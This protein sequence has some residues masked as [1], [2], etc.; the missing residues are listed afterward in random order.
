MAYPD[1]DQPQIIAQIQAYFQLSR[2]V[3]PGFLQGTALDPVNGELGPATSA[4]IAAYIQ[5]HGLGE[6]VRPDDPAY[7]QNLY[8]AV[9][10]GLA[11]NPAIQARLL[12]M[13]DA[14][15]QNP[16]ALEE[17]ALSLFEEQQRL[18]FRRQ[19]TP[20]GLDDQTRDGLH[21]EIDLRLVALQTEFGQAEEAYRL[22][23][24][25]TDPEQRELLRAGN[26][27][28]GL[29]GQVLIA[30]P[31]EERTATMAAAGS[32]KANGN[33]PFQRPA[34]PQVQLA[35]AEGVIATDA[36]P[37]AEPEP[38]PEPE[39]EQPVT[40]GATRQP[41]AQPP[42]R[43][44]ADDYSI[45]FMMNVVLNNGAYGVHTQRVW[46]DI[47]ENQIA[48][49]QAIENY[50]LDFARRY[51]DANGNRPLPDATTATMR[52]QLVTQVAA[53]QTIEGQI[54]GVRPTP[55]Q[56]ADTYIQNRVLPQM[57]QGSRDVYQAMQRDGATFEDAANKWLDDNGG[58]GNPQEREA[59]LAGMRA[60]IDAIPRL[61]EAVRAYE[62]I[63]PTPEDALRV[64]R[65]SWAGIP[66]LPNTPD[67]YA[68]L[69]EQRIAHYQTAAGGDL[70]PMTA[71]SR[72]A[73]DIRAQ[74]DRDNGA[75][76]RAIVDENH[77]YYQSDIMQM[78]DW[79]R[80]RMYAGQQVE[81]AAERGETLSRLDAMKTLDSYGYLAYR[82]TTLEQAMTTAYEQAQ[83]APRPEVQATPLAA[84]P[85][86]EP[87]PVPST[88]NYGDEFH[89]NNPFRM[90]VANA[91]LENP[92]LITEQATNLAWA[93]VHGSE[94]GQVTLEDA[95]RAHHQLRDEDFTGTLTDDQRA[96]LATIAAELG[97]EPGQTF[98]A[99]DPR[100]L[101][102]VAAYAN[103]M[104]VAQLPAEWKQAFAATAA[105][106]TV[107]QP[108]VRAEPAPP[109][110]E[111]AAPIASGLPGRLSDEFTASR[112]AQAAAP[113]L[114]QQTP[115]PSATLAADTEAVFSSLQDSY[116]SYMASLPMAMSRE[117]VQ[118]MRDAQ[119]RF[120]TLQQ[121]HDSGD[122]ARTL[123]ES[124]AFSEFMREGL[125]TR[126]TAFMQQN[127]NQIHPYF[128]HIGETVGATDYAK[129]A[130]V[131]R[132]RQ[133]DIIDATYDHRGAGVREL[134]SERDAFTD[135]D[136]PLQGFEEQS[137]AIATLATSNGIDL[138]APLPAP[139]TP[140]AAAASPPQDQRSWYDP[141]GWF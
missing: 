99:N 133:G 53:L 25:M 14:A 121:A 17:R 21:G 130:E 132:Q 84:E 22:A 66:N 67:H 108:E 9:Q 78:G 71:I 141:R 125:A 45:W 69:L 6:T 23:Q 13:A 83:V 127:W 38:E 126:Q 20:A 103:N 33:R 79:L 48:P 119:Q 34:Q 80:G 95:A 110:T 8:T 101:E 87:V 61:H 131:L 7:L 3:E 89:A 92:A 85:L 29:G 54:Q 64:M 30:D 37:G 27:L 81:A 63:D 96:R 12:A 111:D 136:R 114:E 117:D 128:A 140:D 113:V 88:V 44:P 36:A 123:H 31:A 106:I 16:G 58:Y 112:D 116:M 19:T 15:G 100:L 138:N 18:Q 98:A 118:F 39:E 122:P 77:T 93:I 91:D 49:G 137:R 97:V 115:Q 2:A 75:P 104:T 107:P 94:N 105:N 28:A 62:A 109:V 47:R 90:T 46:Q 72:A 32:L 51:S 52:E 5:E 76:A 4:A 134:L 120:E 56:I 55:E 74:V 86:P 135:I 57:Q 35:Q 1:Y 41:A 68:Q 102:S 82:R 26:A 24:G 11:D 43:P 60:D 73:V 129:G 139:P 50:L 70:D 59:M 42:A 40:T 10:T 124:R 65:E